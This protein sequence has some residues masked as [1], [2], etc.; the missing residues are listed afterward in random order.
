MSDWINVI[1]QK[2]LA[3]GEHIVV[4]V[5][6]TDVA[7]FKIEGQFYAIEDVCTHDGAEIASGK[8]EGC[9]IICPRHGARFCVKT[10]AVKSPPAYEDID[11]F[12]VRIENGKV[13]V[14][15]DRWD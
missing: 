1:D 12:P 5:D 9:E 4:D 15:D 6:G 8:L 14:R 13:Q 2:A 10:G 7:V 3:E 11:T